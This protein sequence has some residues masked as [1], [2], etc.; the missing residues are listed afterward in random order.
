M[1]QERMYKVLLGPVISEKA[2]GAGEQDQ[3]VF[4][5]LPSAE[6]AE[7]KAAVEKLFNVKV[8]GVRTIN[9]K[10]KT[11]RTKH[12]M[13]QKSDWKKAYVRLEQG[14]DIDFAVAE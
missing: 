7:I 6:K 5:V 12:G 1:N 2:A 10:G 8:E 9:V 4:K 3:V 14:Q 11:K 13:G